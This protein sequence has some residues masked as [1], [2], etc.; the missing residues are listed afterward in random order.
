[1]AFTTDIKKSNINENWLFELEYYNGDTGGDGGGGFGQ[2][3]LS[4]G[5]TPLLLNGAIDDD[6]ET[7]TIRLDINTMFQIGDFIKI[8]SEIM[9]I[10]AVI[11]GETVLVGV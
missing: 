10:T 5:T 3:F 4:N 1:M 8:D 9:E 6:V 2:V 11:V 7:T